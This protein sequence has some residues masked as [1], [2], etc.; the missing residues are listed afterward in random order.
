M[1]VRTI[2]I[3][4]NAGKKFTYVGGKGSLFICLINAFSPR[5]KM[6]IELNLFY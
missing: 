2:K 6:K 5:I 1:Q 3:L 4:A